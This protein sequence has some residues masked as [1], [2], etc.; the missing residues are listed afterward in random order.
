[1]YKKWLRTFGNF[2]LLITVGLFY[3]FSI[4]FIWM[5]IL[6]LETF[7]HFWKYK[8]ESLYYDNMVILQTKITKKLEK[9]TL[10]R[11]QRLLLRISQK[12][13]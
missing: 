10:A 9:V 13:L 6:L 12:I 5:T 3:F 8:K 11:S 4:C 7:R 2:I 1:M